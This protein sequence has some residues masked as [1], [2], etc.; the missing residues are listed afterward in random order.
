MRRVPLLLCA[1]AVLVAG[2][3]SST[4]PAK[5][6]HPP[7][8]GPQAKA[9]PAKLRRAGGI[10]ATLLQEVRPIGRGPR[11]EPPVRGPVPGACVTRLGRR[12]EAHIEVFGANRVVLLPAGIG[13]EPPRVVS[14]GR[15]THARCFGS[16]VT[17]DPTGTVY[18]RARP[19]LTLGDLFTAWGHALSSTRIASFSGSRVRVFVNG[20]AFAGSPRRIALTERAEIVLEV[21]PR[22]PPHT[23]FTFPRSPSVGLH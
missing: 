23:H 11:F 6:S 1:A 21:G 2:C 4:P 12:L 7:T 16:L 10:P 9:P 3:G 20:R 22:I 13:T 15:L 8:P 5:G 17:L 18:F 19:R 14:D